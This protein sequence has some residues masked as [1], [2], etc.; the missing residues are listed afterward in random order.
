MK[1]TSPERTGNKNMNPDLPPLPRLFQNKIITIAVG[2]VWFG[3]L[4]TLSLEPFTFPVIVWIAPWP[5]FYFATRFRDNILA[6]AGIGAICA[7]TLCT[8]SF[9][10][11]LH[12]FQT[13]GGL[14]LFLA[15]LIFVP[16]TVLLNLKIPLFLVLFGLA[17]RHRTRL[18]PLWFVAAF[19]A[20]ISDTISPQ[21]FPWY[22]GNLA[23]HNR[24]LAQ[25]AEFT[26]IHGISFMMF[27]GSYG[28]Y[29]VMRHLSV[30]TN[31]LTNLQGRLAQILLKH[32]WSPDSGKVIAS[33][34]PGLFALCLGFGQIR[35]H[36]FTEIEKTLPK[37]RVAMIQP[38]APLEKPG[39][40]HVTDE[41]ILDLIRNRIP[42]LVA[43]AR[44]YGPLNLVVL[45]ES[46]VP[47]YTTQNNMLTNASRIYWRPFEEM[48]QQIARTTGASVYFNE[49]A[50]DIVWD[51]IRDRPRS[52]AYNSSTLYSPDGARRQ[53]YSKRVLLAFGEYIPGVELME[54]TGL[55][56][57]V[58]EAVRYSR[59]ERGATSHE[60][61]YYRQP[62]ESP[63]PAVKPQPSGAPVLSVDP[64]TNSKLKPSASIGTFLPLIC[65]EI[66]IPDYVRL[67][68][69]GQNPG[70]IVNITQDGWYGRT[71]ETYQHFGLGRIR[72]IELRRALV[73]STNSGSSGFVNLTGDVVVPLRGP[74]LS[75]QEVEE[76]QVWDV[77]VYNAEPT[78]FAKYGLSWI[79]WIT[80]ATLLWTAGIFY[81][82]GKGVR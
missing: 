59:F 26:G 81:K 63:V 46:G 25:I 65:Y 35:L 23:A 37:V 24:A 11:L 13:F 29:S 60:M 78:F 80:I 73:R 8:F 2:A 56:F 41:L 74:R 53:S 31:G 19:L 21:V 38:N 6:L 50:M 72:S 51:K 36:Q 22:W 20:L 48:V 28:L 42:T 75:A 77:P 54:K 61:H 45:P 14:N 79:L 15:F 39:E 16:Y 5:L 71:V 49:I 27:A 17:E 70:F 82:T 62:E 44:E 57:L 1:K 40:N 58:P 69:E 30:N 67:F 33:I 10:W 34:L 18:P 55:I 64:Q 3:G 76:V 43:T 4:C 66:L 9:Y 52:G 47:Y 32:T 12:L 68:M 7:A